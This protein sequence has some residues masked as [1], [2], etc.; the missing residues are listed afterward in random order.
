MEVKNPKTNRI[1][2]DKTNRKVLFPRQQTAGVSENWRFEA[3]NETFI[4]DLKVIRIK[5]IT[6]NA[7]RFCRV[8]T[9]LLIYS[10]VHFGK[11]KTTCSRPPERVPGF[12]VGA[13]RSFICFGGEGEPGKIRKRPL[14]SCNFLGRR[15]TNDKKQTTS[16]ES[17]K[18][19]N[20]SL[21][22]NTW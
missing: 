2:R 21:A 16:L 8:S 19:A 6:I 1:F 17:R 9:C 12:R 10:N 13:Y 15:K 5:E 14:G 11:R 22:D 4:E 18:T 3:E 7:Y 20:V